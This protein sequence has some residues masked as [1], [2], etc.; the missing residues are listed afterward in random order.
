MSAQ[1]NFYITIT[2][3]SSTFTGLKTSGYNLFG[4]VGVVSSN[5]SG[6]PAVAVCTNAYLQNNIVTLSGQLTAY[7]SISQI[8][9]NST[10]TIGS[11]AAI[12]TGQIATIDP[13]GSLSVASG[14]PA[15]TVYF[16]NGASTSY[17][18]GIARSL[19]LSNV[20]SSAVPSVAF[21]AQPTFMVTTAPTGSALFF[22]GTPTYRAGTIL[23]TCF[24]SA[25]A[26]DLATA[27]ADGVT[28]VYDQTQGGWLTNNASYLTKIAAGSS[29]TPV[30]IQQPGPD[31]PA[32]FALMIQDDPL[33][34]PGDDSDRTDLG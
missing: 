22:F 28:L 16:V 19:S 12:A 30:L 27:P 32:A 23:T 20:P 31:T 6:R 1:S 29:I 7:D 5:K 34:V 14:A 2:I 13:S 17:T 4:M 8:A 9:D 3:E 21:N 11:P 24:G 18:V 10:I 25:V 15:G 26:I 33:A